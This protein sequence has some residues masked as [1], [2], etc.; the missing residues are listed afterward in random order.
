LLQQ[1]KERL[2][3]E[4]EGFKKQRT[5]TDKGSRSLFQIENVSQKGYLGPQGKE[6][7][8]FFPACQ[9][10]KMYHK[11]GIWALK[12]KNRA[13]FPGMPNNRRCPNPMKTLP[14]SILQKTC[15]IRPTSFSHSK[16]IVC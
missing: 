14:N 15:L 7:G 13:I 2:P 16:S 11:R 4:A 10:I 5:D 12:E 6:R 8:Q 1:Q 9:T 3:W